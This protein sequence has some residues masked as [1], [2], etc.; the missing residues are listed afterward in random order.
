MVRD[1]MFGGYIAEALVVGEKAGNRCGRVR[2]QTGEHFGE[3]RN[4]G[5]YDLLEYVTAGEA[6]AILASVWPD[7]DV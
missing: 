4:P 1:V 5:E 3:A 2:L 6:P 7:Q